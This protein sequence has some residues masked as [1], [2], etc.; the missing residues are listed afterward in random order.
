MLH[1]L[2]LTES[3]HCSCNGDS[4]HLQVGCKPVTVNMALT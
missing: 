1:M 4:L 3:C 2:I